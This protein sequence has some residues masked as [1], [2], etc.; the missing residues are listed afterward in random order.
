MNGPDPASALLVPDLL[1]HGA[2]R[3]PDRPCVI[4]D[5]RTIGFREASDRASQLAALLR[6]RGLGEG[7][8]VALLALNEPELIE[9]RAGTQRAGAM[10]VP[11]NYRL[12]E[13]ELREIVADCEP[14]LLIAGP[15]YASVAARLGVPTV[16]ELGLDVTGD[17]SYEQAIAAHP[18]APPPAA[19]DGATV[20]LL[21]YTSGTTSRPKGVMLSN[22]N[23]HA[24]T[25]AMGHEIGASPDGT[26]LACAPMFHIGHT[27]GFSFTQLGGTHRQLRK[28]DVDAF[29]ALTADGAVTHTQLVPAMIHAVLE[30]GGAQPRGLRRILYGAAPMPPELT[31]RVYAAW[32]CEFVNG[33]GSTEAMGISMLPPEDH[34]PDSA[35]ELLGSVGRSSVAS[36]VRLVD[37]EDRDVADGQ[38]GEVIVRGPTV[39]CGYWRNPEATA[40]ALRGGWMHTGDLGYR[41]ERGYL[42]LVDRR[43]DKIV[44]GGENVYPSEV[45]HR[46]LEHPAVLEAAVVG[47]ADDR[48]GEAVCAAVVLRDGAE[49]DADALRTHCRETLTG[50]KVP[51]QIRV[52]RTLPRTATGKLRRGELRD[53]WSALDAPPAP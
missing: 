2:R 50:Y 10:L 53:G 4:V 48:W 32:G 34:D 20:T 1:A 39:M 5:D 52:V 51:K 13:P 43:H 6:D 37:G 40:E 7:R 11:L 23:A 15:G 14:D 22:W 21:A 9:I 19:L 33:F 29:R 18:T 26:Y 44:T 31:R 16:L 36:S 8:R 46:L 25:V 49:V 30:R 12:S 3:Y 27:V 38:V 41:D 28:F 17:R 24:T 35:P 45:E 47:I 42:F